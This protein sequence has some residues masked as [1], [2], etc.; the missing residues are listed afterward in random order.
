MGDTVRWGGEHHD[1]EWRFV[2]ENAHCAQDPCEVHYR[3]CLVAPDGRILVHDA[4]ITGAEH[5]VWGRIREALDRPML[6]I[7]RELPA[8]DVYAVPFAKK[9]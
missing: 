8:K 6:R 2:V 4:L 1:G 9:D 3:L 5:G 7:P